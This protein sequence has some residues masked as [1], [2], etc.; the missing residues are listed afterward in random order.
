MMQRLSVMSSH[1]SFFAWHAP[2]ISHLSLHDM[3]L[4]SSMAECSTHMLNMLVLAV[5]VHTAWPVMPGH[6]PC[7]MQLEIDR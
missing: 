4:L 1:F 2:T 6:G 7:F 5:S 3:H